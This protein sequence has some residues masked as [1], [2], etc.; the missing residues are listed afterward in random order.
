LQEQLSPRAQVH[1]A[2]LQDLARAPDPNPFT[3]CQAQSPPVLQDD[4]EIVDAFELGLQVSE[5]AAEEV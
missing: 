2:A 1:G 3:K 4:H 5:Y